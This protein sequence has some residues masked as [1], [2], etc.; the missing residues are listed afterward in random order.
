[1]DNNKLRLSL[2]W[3]PDRSGI[4]FV[5]F[6]HYVGSDPPPKTAYKSIYHISAING[7]ISLFATVT[8]LLDEVAPIVAITNGVDAWLSGANMSSAA[9]AADPAVIAW[10]VKDRSGT[11]LVYQSVVSGNAGITMNMQILNGAFYI[12][13]AY[14]FPYLVASVN[15]GP[16]A[17]KSETPAP[18][19]ILF[20]AQN[21]VTPNL[22]TTAVPNKIFMYSET[23]IYGSADTGQYAAYK[24]YKVHSCKSL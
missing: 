14:T 15:G 16:A 7:S 18:I 20:N 11:P 1:M 19:T 13:Y 12:S 10:T 17:M 9:L 21:G 2:S 6:E 23:E 22:L 3:S 8:D 5:C 4:T 24:V